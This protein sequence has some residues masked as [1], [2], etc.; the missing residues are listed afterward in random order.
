MRQMSL[1]NTIGKKRVTINI[2]FKYTYDD[3]KAM[4]ISYKATNDI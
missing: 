2:F 1:L 4:I 3:T